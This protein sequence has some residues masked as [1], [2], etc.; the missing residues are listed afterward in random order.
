[1]IEIQLRIFCN[2]KNVPV[3]FYFSLSENKELRVFIEYLLQ[4]GT[5]FSITHVTDDS[6]KTRKG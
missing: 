6:G 3:I 2:P 4:H 5:D 1:M